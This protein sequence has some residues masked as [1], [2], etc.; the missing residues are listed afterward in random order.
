MLLSD[1]CFADQ[2][3]KL[4]TMLSSLPLHKRDS[5]SILSLYHR[6][7]NLSSHLVSGHPYILTFS[8]PYRFRFVSP[9]GVDQRE[10]DEIAK[11]D[12]TLLMTEFKVLDRIRV[13]FKDQEG[14]F[15]YRY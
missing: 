14:A 11:C 9:R 2:K 12:E 5:S 1:W 4:G 3:D 8:Y 13:N 6:Y 10:I 15:G 7:R